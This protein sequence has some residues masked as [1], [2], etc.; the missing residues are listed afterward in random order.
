EVTPNLLSKVEIKIACNDQFVDIIVQTIMKAARH[1]EGA[2]GDG[3][4]FV[5]PLERCYR[6][7]TGESGNGAI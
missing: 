2:I 4:I 6:I 3:K 1:G 5:L 7:R